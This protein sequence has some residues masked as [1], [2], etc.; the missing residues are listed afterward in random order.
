MITA[1]DTSVLVAISKQEIRGKEWKECLKSAAR[2]GS[3]II[4]PVVFAEY[5]TRFHDLGAVRE[6]LSDL[7]LRW[8]SFSDEAAYLAGRTYIRYR[9]NKGP[10]RTMIPDF[11]IAAHAKTQ[12]DR[13]AAIDR[14]YLRNYFADLKLL[15]P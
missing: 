15:T 11:L 8:S 2:Q 14:G 6:V 12:A 1:V 10:R 13:L 3:L 5:S 4:C 9:R 7:S